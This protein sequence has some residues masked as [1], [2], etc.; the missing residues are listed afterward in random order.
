[1]PYAALQ[2]TVFELPA[3]KETGG[4]FALAYAGKT[5]TSPRTELGLRTDKSFAVNDAILTLR[6]RAA[7]AHDTNTDRSATATFQLLPGSRTVRRS[8]ATRR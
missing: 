1:M 2:A 8:R 7:W 3:Y 6:G 5:V 4:T